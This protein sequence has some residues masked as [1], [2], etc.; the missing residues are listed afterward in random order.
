MKGNVL[1]K[2]SFLCALIAD[3]VEITL[4][5]EQEKLGKDKRLTKAT[6]KICTGCKHKVWE[7]PNLSRAKLR[8]VN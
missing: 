8:D 2:F 5:F 6:K 1:V 3:V 7:S 4:C